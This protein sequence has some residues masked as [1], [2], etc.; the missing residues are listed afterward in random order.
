MNEQIKEILLKQLQLLREAC[1][2]DMTPEEAARMAEA[3]G[4][5]N[6]GA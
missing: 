5:L 1:E 4:A 6:T 2:K 3:L